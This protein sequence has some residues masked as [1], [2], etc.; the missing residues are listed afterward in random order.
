VR[1]RRCALHRRLAD[2]LAKQ[3]RAASPDGASRIGH[4]YE[5]AGDAQAAVHHL[6][7]AGRGYAELRA[8]P[9]AALHLR[10]AFALARER[11]AEDPALA[12][13][14][15]LSLAA[16]LVTLDRSGEAAAVLEGLDL[17]RA[18]VGDR[19]PLALAQIQAG[20]MRFSNENDVA[21]GRALVARGL[22]LAEGLGG[23]EDV[24]LLAHIFLSR[25]E[26]LDG[27]LVRALAVAQRA[28]EL[29][30]ARGDATSGAVGHQNECAVH[31]E[32][33]RLAEAR[34]S[35]G[36]ALRS[37]R[38]AESDV[39]LGMAHMALARVAMLSGDVEGA[40]AAAARAHEAGARSG[41]V[42]LCYNAAVSAGYAHLLAGSPRAAHDA[43]EGLAALNDRWPSTWLHRAR[44][45]LEVGELAE[46]A[47]LAARCLA[48]GAPRGIRARALAVRGLALGLGGG[49]RD[50]ADALLAEALELC[51]ALGLRPALA[52]AEAFLAEVAARRG[53]AAR[54]E[55]WAERAA[56]EYARCGMALHATEARRLL[57][58]AAS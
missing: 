52:E 4:H 54:A 42:G 50:E 22:R 45:K 19:L 30:A 51:D 33:G 40:L 28:I 35:A 9:E 12:A 48:S 43:F 5:R 55:R 49:P 15:G 38:I 20:W 44:G 31:C 34:E 2:V 39:A 32:A 24:Q 41:Q 18:A 6:L 27:E 1:E 37:A 3:P 53:D 16:A 10:R 58:E 56:E 23:S 46:A 47:E 29:A 14:V 26:L 57:S 21:R 13:S 25:I 17:E 7:R 36:E 8:L 11:E